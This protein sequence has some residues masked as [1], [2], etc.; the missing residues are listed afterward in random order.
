MLEQSLGLDGVEHRERSRARDGVATEGGAV[1]ARLEQVG[2]PTEPDDGPDREATAQALG[3]GDDVG[4][5]T[6]PQVRQPVTGAPDAALHLVEPQQCTVL[7][8]DAAR[9]GEVA[10]GRHHDAGLALD[11]LQA[12]GRGLVGHGGGECVGVAVRDEGDVTGQRLERL[13]VGGLRGQR[14]RAHGA[15]VEPALGHDDVGATGAPGELEGPLVGL[16]AG[17][18]EEDLAALL[19]G[20]VTEQGEQALGQLDLRAGGEEV[21]D[22]PQGLQLLGHRADQG[23]VAVPEGVDGDAGE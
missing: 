10:L 2:R 6:V 22:V 16:G 20:G 11:R 4:H 15:A 19:R 17:V 13:A 1:V 21:G 9:R 3:E 14:E 12:D 8:G 23:R 5:D 7:V 18:G